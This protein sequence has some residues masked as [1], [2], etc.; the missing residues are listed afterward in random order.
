MSGVAAY[1]AYGLTLTSDLP[2]PELPSSDGPPDLHVTWQTARAPLAGRWEVFWRASSGEVW[3]ALGRHGAMRELRFPRYLSVRFNETAIVASRRGHAEWATVRHLFLDQSLPVVLALRGGL[4][5]HA[6][7]VRVGEQ[8]VLLLGPS[9]AG[10]STLA[11]MLGGRGSDVLADDGVLIRDGRNGPEAVPSYPGLR[12]FDDAAEVA[13]LPVEQVKRMAGYSRKRRYSVESSTG[14]A[15]PL[16]P[17]YLL[18]TAAAPLA[19]QRVSIR[20]VAVQLLRYAFRAELSDRTRLAA[21]FEMV[22]RWAPRLD[23]WYLP[24]PRRLAE[25]GQV[26][27]ALLAHARRRLTAPGN[28]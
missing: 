6:S 5:L 14:S 11:A 19:I 10:K 27:D 20:D 22:S 25:A 1:G 16:G 9:G 7:S 28:S 13:G 12:L 24:H 23:V 21:E 4:V 15:L 3:M 17:I 26:A 2:F 8:A 18:D